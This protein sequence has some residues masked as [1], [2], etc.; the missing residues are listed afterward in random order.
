MVE[1]LDN[2]LWLDIKNYE[3][4]YQISN[5]GRIKSFRVDK[6]GKL[7]SQRLVRGYNK[8]SFKI[9]GKNKDYYVHRLVMENFNPIE[10]MDKMEVNHKDENKMNNCLSNLE[11]LTHRENLCYGTRGKRAGDKMR[12][13]SPLKKKVF[14]VE[15]ELEFESI[16]EAARILGIPST[17]ICQCCK[18]EN[19]TINGYHWRYSKCDKEVRQ[20]KKKCGPIGGE[21][22]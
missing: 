7:L 21:S 2:E 17:N 15:L 11:W 6:T 8:V 13:N 3:G 12:E 22:K 5:Y 4:M 16:R 1:N 14:C 18:H 20:E 9:N 19:R 10:N